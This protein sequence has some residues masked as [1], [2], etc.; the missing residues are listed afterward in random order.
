[1]QM[2]IPQCFVPIPNC[3]QALLFSFRRTPDRWF[4]SSKNH[5]F[6]T[7]L[8]SKTFAFGNFS[9]ESQ[10]IYSASHEATLL[11]LKQKLACLG[12]HSRMKRSG[13]VEKKLN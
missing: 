3:D 13:V 1:V 9:T 7:L 12:T 4:I 2:I 5:L 11:K 8:F 6:S 10:C